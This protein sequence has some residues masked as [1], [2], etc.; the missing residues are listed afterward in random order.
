MAPFQRRLQGSFHN[1]KESRINLVLVSE[2][3]HMNLAGI[4]LRIILRSRCA[5]T[6]LVVYQGALH[7]SH[8]A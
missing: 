1:G 5:G 6:D 3:N 4:E 2:L 8:F 7:F